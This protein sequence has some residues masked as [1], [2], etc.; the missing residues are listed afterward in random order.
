MFGAIIT[1]AMAMNN[2][3]GEIKRNEIMGF[4]SLDKLMGRNNAAVEKVASLLKELSPSALRQLKLLAVENLN[5]EDIITKQIF[6]AILIAGCRREINK[7]IVGYEETLTPLIK[8]Y[9]ETFE[10]DYLLTH[11]NGVE[12]LNAFFHPIG[13]T[14]GEFNNKNEGSHEILINKR[15]YNQILKSFIGWLKNSEG[16]KKIRPLRKNLEEC[17]RISNKE[18]IEEKR[19]WS[20]IEKVLNLLCPNPED[21]FLKA[22]DVQKYLSAEESIKNDAKDTPEFGF[23]SSFNAKAQLRK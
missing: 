22:A 16:Y 3:A 12:A 5:K 20:L 15:R 9:A 4:K 14:D 8:P 19:D 18:E 7:R 13:P 11:T 17:F 1:N 10:S 6:R 2:S 23:I 21:I